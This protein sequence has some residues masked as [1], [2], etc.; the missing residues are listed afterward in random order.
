MKKRIFWLYQMS[1]FFAN[2][3]HLSITQKTADICPYVSYV[4]RKIKTSKNVNTVKRKLHLFRKYILIKIII[5]FYLLR[6][7]SSVITPRNC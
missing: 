7:Y 1:V 4:L 5:L 3:I 2:K 6:I